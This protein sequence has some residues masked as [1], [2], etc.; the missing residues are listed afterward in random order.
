MKRNDRSHRQT[1]FLFFLILSVV[2]LLLPLARTNA[3]ASCSAACDPGCHGLTGSCS[4]G[5]PRTACACAGGG[6]GPYSCC[7]YYDGNYI[8]GDGNC[9]FNSNI[10]TPAGWL[11]QNKCRAESAASLL[12]VSAWTASDGTEIQIFTPVT[13][14][15]P[16]QITDVKYEKVPGGFKNLTYNI[17]NDSKE[18]LAAVEVMLE[19]S[20]GSAVSRSP[21]YIDAWPSGPGIA[22]NSTGEVPHGISM[23]SKTGQISRISVTIGA[24]VFSDGTGAGPDL[25]EFRN[26]LQQEHLLMQ[27]QAAKIKASLDSQGLP[28]A[29]GMVADSTNASSQVRRANYLMQTSLQR[30]GEPGLRT[31]ISEILN[32]KP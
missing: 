30:N 11:P 22:G 19:V 32:S 23:Q 25:V 17:R 14:G 12:V 10:V 9:G 15:V 21:Q 7:G 1:S 2:L 8:C 3:Y 6:C 28:V 27:A 29:T 26:F 20:D 4:C 13:A 16:V 31:Q 18:R 5:P 24:V